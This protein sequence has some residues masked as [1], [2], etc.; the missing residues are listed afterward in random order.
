MI[1][2]KWKKL[3]KYSSKNIQNSRNCAA[4]IM[5]L[6]LILVNVGSVGLIH[7]HRDQSFVASAA[8]FLTCHI[9]LGG[10]SIEAAILGLQELLGGHLL[11]RRRLEGVILPH[12]GG[13]DI[14]CD[15]H[16]L[17][18]PELS[19]NWYQLFLCNRPDSPTHPRRHVTW[20]GLRL[21]RVLRHSVSVVIISQTP[22]TEGGGVMISDDVTL[23]EPVILNSSSQN[24]DFLWY[25]PAIFSE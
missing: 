6:I 7:T 22:R 12:L 2:G 14:H 20:P 8:Q 13:G 1:L 4:A 17:T 18:G 23:A 19:H 5:L 15:S 3:Q 10:L 11:L 21:C 16:V 24:S 25:L 9:P